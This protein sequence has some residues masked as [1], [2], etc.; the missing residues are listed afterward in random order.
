MIVSANYE[1]WSY[2]DIYCPFNTTA[3][4]PFEDVGLVHD[5]ADLLTMRS[6]TVGE[7]HADLIMCS[8]S[9]FRSS[10]KFRLLSKTSITEMMFNVLASI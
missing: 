2:S 1:M 9:R 4:N 3:C 10:S 6:W 7:A 5:L 8:I